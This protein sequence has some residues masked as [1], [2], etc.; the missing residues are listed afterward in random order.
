MPGVGLRLEEGLQ[1]VEHRLAIPTAVRNSRIISMDESSSGPK[2]V[3]K[4]EPLHPNRSDQF[5]SIHRAHGEASHAD[6]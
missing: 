4:P 3:A 2:V 6:R 1:L 5:S